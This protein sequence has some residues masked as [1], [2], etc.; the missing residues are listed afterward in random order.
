MG[1]S[2]VLIMKSNATTQTMKEESEKFFG[3][4]RVW[5]IDTHRPET[6]CL[7]TIHQFILGSSSI[8]ILQNRGICG[9]YEF[10]PS[11]C[12]A[13]YIRLFKVLLYEAVFGALLKKG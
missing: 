8:E 1:I 9:T 7:Q 6:G 5:E 11:V 13:V 4:L 10:V 12:A 2:F 3:R